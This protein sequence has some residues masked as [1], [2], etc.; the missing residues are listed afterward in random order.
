M[1]I[2]WHQDQ[3]SGMEYPLGSW[4]IPE[5]EQQGGDEEQIIMVLPKWGHMH[6]STKLHVKN[7][8]SRWARWGVYFVVDSLSTYTL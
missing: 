6:F 8:I 3:V 4:S 2:I 1:T 5:R 7:Q